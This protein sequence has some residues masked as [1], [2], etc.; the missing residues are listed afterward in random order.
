MSFSFFDRTEL[1]AARSQRIVDDALSGCDDG[2][3]Y[4]EYAQSE[5]FVFDDGRLKTASYDVSQGLGLRAVLGETSAYAHASE[6]SEESLKRAASSVAAVRTGAWARW[7]KAR[8]AP[9]A[10]YI[11]TPIRS[12]P[13][14]SR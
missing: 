8:P 6:L 13:S 12:K 14:P 2:E 9:I 7:A 10:L 5:A 4:L 1:D 11:R 3:L